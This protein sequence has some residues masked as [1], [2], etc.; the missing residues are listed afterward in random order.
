MDNQGGATPPNA[1]VNSP[2]APAPAPAPSSLK[3]LESD[4]SGRAASAKSPAEIRAVISQAKRAVPTPPATDPTLPVE[5]AAAP[6]PEP[7]PAAEPASEPAAAEPTPEGTSAEPEAPAAQPEPGDEPEGDEGDGPIQP[8]TAKKLRLRLPE[9]DKLGRLTVAI[10]QRNRDLTLDEANAMARKQLGMTPSVDVPNG[11]TPPAT[12]EL[13]QTVEEVD[14]TLE[15]LVADMEKAQV[16]LRFEDAVKA[17]RQIRRL[18]LHRFGLERQAERKQ[19]EAVASYE[20]GFSESEAKAAELYAFAN[21]PES[22]AG[23]RMAE[24]EESMKEMGDPLYFSPE[25][26]LK[27][28]QMVAAEFNIAPRKKGAAAAP[29]K[30]AAPPATPPAITKPKQMLPTGGSRTVPPVVNQQPAIVEAVQ[31]LGNRDQYGLRKLLKT[32]GVK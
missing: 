12:P 31:K 28:A 8:S 15:A 20:K 23:K 25:K 3:T 26:P 14:K 24:I 11:T 21:D 18:D 9:A 2:A 32:V 10:L 1:T 22:P 7:A 4:L 6:T 17:Q 16:E 5:P 27:I 29:V 30:P 13:P 19:A